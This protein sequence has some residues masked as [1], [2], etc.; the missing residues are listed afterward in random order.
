MEL[1]GFN[2]ILGIAFEH[3][4]EQHYSI[5]THFISTKAKF[6]KRIKDD[7]I[8]Y[9]LCLK[10]NIKLILVP[11]IP[12]L[13]PIDSVKDFIK[14]QCKQKNIIL[15]SNFSIKKVNLINAYSIFTSKE[16]L[17]DLKNIA[18]K[19][20]GKCLSEVYINDYTK[21]LWECK[22]GHRWESV[23]ASIKQNTWC[24]YCAGIVKKTIEQ[25]QILATKRGG[26]CI[27]RKYN[28][29]RNKL[30]WECSKV[31]KFEMTP[32]QAKNHWCPYCA[33]RG[34][35]IHDMNNIAHKKGG[36][37]LSDSFMGMTKKHLWECRE[38]H[39]WEAVPD[40][41]RRGSWCPTC[42]STKITIKQMKEL[43]RNNGGKCLSTQYVNAQTKLLWQCLNGHQ[44]LAS[45]SHI[46]Q[47]SWCPRCAGHGKTIDDMHHL[48][49]QYNGKCLSE[50][51]V[52]ASTKLRWQCEK[53]HI[54]LAAPKRVLEGRWCSE[55]RK[56]ERHINNKIKLSQ[57][58]TPL[59]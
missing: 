23:P 55:C 50:S 9:K 15:P 8:K 29:N 27:S 11:E 56:F 58:T 10:Y 5:K 43:A 44:W 26:K 2:K 24:P 7:K 6:D 35:T 25:M 31:H 32:G 18:N 47:G 57:K 39:Q 30:T 59:I 42:W 40:S 16:I 45:P 1:D 22:E 54:W 41:I 12:R 48:A 49:A 38:G 36:K 51:Y 20:G 52:N 19:R 17:N 21:L 34:R 14:E 53:G 13:L 46:K 37:C 33:G 28:N 4:G 3:Q